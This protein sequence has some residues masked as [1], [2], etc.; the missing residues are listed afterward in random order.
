MGSRVETLNAGGYRS[1]GRRQHE[2][3]N[4]SIDFSSSSNSSA[5]GSS[6]VSHGLTTVMA[7]VFGPREARLRS[8]TLHDRAVVNVEVA[9]SPFSSGERR[10]RGRGDKRIL[11][12]AAAIKATFEPVIQTHLYPRSQ[13]DIFVQVLDQDGG[14]LQT[15][16]NATTLALINAGVPMSDYVCAIT[17]GVFSTQPLLDLTLLEESDIPHLTLAVM[18]KTNNVTL[19][20]METRL[21]VDRFEELIRLALSATKVLHTEMR[22]VVRLQT[23][24]LV[25]TMGKS[26]VARTIGREVAPADDFDEPMQDV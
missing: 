18:P 19:V 4:I 1:D 26:G 22:T 12:F 7:S 13:I 24:D 11:E 15:S 2:L 10:R 20:T 3:R 17:C 8:L 6:T 23:A 16:I 5:D 14:L 9:I 25:R 21:H